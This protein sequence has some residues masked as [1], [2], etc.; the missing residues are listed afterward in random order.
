MREKILWPL[1]EWRTVYSMD[2][3]LDPARRP[4]WLV[5]RLSCE[6]LPEVSVT[7]DR[8]EVVRL[9]RKLRHDARL[10]LCEKFFAARAHLA[11]FTVLYRFAGRLTA[12]RQEAPTA[13]DAAHAVSGAVGGKCAI[14]A[15]MPGVVEFAQ[16][17][18]LEGIFRFWD[19]AQ[20]SPTIELIPWKH[21]H[22]V[23]Q[24]GARTIK[25]LR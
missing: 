16:G 6:G 20:V 19:H 17:A 15:V 7:R 13:N 18:D 8:E 2:Y 9:F 5:A 25:W 23:D 4:A 24:R 22:A 3:P 10:K 21:V 11:A 12:L 1:L 14:I